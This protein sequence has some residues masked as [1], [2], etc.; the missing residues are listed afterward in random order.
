MNDVLPVIKKN[1][2]NALNSSRLSSNSKLNKLKLPIMNNNIESKKNLSDD[3]NLTL[4]IKKKFEKLPNLPKPVAKK[5]SVEH[6]KVIAKFRLT[7]YVT[8]ESRPTNSP[9]DLF[10]PV[11]TNA[12]PNDNFKTKND[13]DSKLTTIYHRLNE[14][15][16]IRLTGRVKT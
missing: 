7:K 14:N 13:K 12:D 3:S 15:S 10:T 9:M 1:E 16:Y 6:N 5:F 8:N 2:K 11:T 4:K